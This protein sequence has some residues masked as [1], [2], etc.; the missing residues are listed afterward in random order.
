MTAT[1]KPKPPKLTD[2]ERHARFVEMAHEVGVDEDPDAF[3]R[4]FDRLRVKLA[5]PGETPQGSDSKP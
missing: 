5:S 1:P 3:D 4:A 2:A